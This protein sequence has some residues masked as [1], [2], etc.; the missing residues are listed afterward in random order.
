MLGGGLLWPEPKQ[1]GD[2]LTCVTSV[3]ARAGIALGSWL[4][5][6]EMKMQGMVITS[7][8][9][10]LSVFLLGPFFAVLIPLLMVSSS[11]GRGEKGSLARS[12]IFFLTNL[13]RQYTQ[14]KH[15]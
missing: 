10:A 2:V 11:M 15:I 9:F 14:H 8:F 7:F 4:R 3:S 5:I 1:L 12:R 13:V 6:G